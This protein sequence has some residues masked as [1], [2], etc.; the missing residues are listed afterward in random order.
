MKVSLKCIMPQCASGGVKVNSFVKFG[1]VTHKVNKCMGNLEVYR[2][3][4]IGMLVKLL[5]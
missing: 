5:H 2:S 1:L 3:L 4:T